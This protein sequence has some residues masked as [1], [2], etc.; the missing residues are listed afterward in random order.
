[1]LKIKFKMSIT[2]HSQTNEQT[3]KT[4]QSLKQYLKYYINNT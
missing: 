3:K 1:M 4:N 2:F